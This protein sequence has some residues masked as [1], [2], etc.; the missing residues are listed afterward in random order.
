MK[1]QFQSKISRIAL[2]LVSGCTLLSAGAAWAET[3]ASLDDQLKSLNFPSNQAPAG[4]SEEKLYAVQS[5]Y[6]PLKGRHEFTFAGA[7]NFT[8][9]G[10][11]NSNELQ[12]GYRFHLSDKVAVGLGYSYVFNSLNSA[13]QRLV[14][15][16]RVLPYTPFVKTRIEMLFE[17]NTMYGKIRLGLNDVVYFDQF[18]SIGPGWIQENSGNSAAAVADVGLAFWLGKTGS[19]RVGLKDYLFDEQRTKSTEMANHIVGHLDI[20]ILL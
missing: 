1:N 5:R 15:E 16:D 6:S 17:Y 14:D 18:V 20:G 12:L 2:G 11:L 10:F 4:I 9:D 3:K 19:I 8:P 13:G 7:K